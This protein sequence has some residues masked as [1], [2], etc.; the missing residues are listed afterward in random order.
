MV[1]E[2]DDVEVFDASQQGWSP[3]SLVYRDRS[4]AHVVIVAGRC[5]DENDPHGVVITEETAMSRGWTVGTSLEVGSDGDV[6]GPRPRNLRAGRTRERLLVRGDPQL[7]RPVAQ[8]A[9]A[10]VPHGDAVLVSASY[11]DKVAP[12]RLART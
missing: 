10:V 11:W 3:L 7:L 4:C 8:F 9:K 2:S 12:P 6:D 5:L 1:T